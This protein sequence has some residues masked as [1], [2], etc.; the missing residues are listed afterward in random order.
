M[1]NWGVLELLEELIWSTNFFSRQCN[2][3][4]NGPE[5]CR[6]LCCGRGYRT[7]VDEKIERCQCK[8]Y[9]CCYVKCKICRTMTQNLILTIQQNGP[10]K[11]PVKCELIRNKKL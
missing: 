10:V 7:V 6:Q 8:F 5:S 4:T 11:N 9:N 3:T 2:V 1:K